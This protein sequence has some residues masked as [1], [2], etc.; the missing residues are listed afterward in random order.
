MFKAIIDARSIF[1]ETPSTYFV[2]VA[3]IFVSHFSLSQVL[4]GDLPLRSVE[5]PLIEEECQIAFLEP[6]IN[7]RPVLLE[8]PST[9]LVVVA[10]VLLSHLPFLQALPSHQMLDD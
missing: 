3:E 6:I 2:S 10:H 9:D 5:L 8:A 4:L 1:L 7:V